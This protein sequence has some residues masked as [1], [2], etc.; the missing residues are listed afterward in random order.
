MSSMTCLVTLNRLVR[1]VSMTASQSA[2]VILRNMPSRV[3]PALLTSTSTGPCSARTLANAAT[4]E[5]QS[6]T[7]PIEA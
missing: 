6:P 2:R 7:L 1:L 3:M 4:V 5:S